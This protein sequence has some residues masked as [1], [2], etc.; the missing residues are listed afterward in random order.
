MDYYT[1]YMKYKQKYVT[2]Q[3]NY[4]EEYMK[5]QYGG[6]ISNDSVKIGLIDFI[7][8]Y[9]H[10]VA[11]GDNKHKPTNFYQFNT[12]EFKAALDNDTTSTEE[13]I[14]LVYF[15][16]RYITDDLE[17]V[18]SYVYKIYMS[19]IPFIHSEYGALKKEPAKDKE[20]SKSFKE[21][22]KD[23]FTFKTKA[24][25]EIK[26]KNPD[27][28]N[29]DIDETIAD[30]TK[31]ED[32]DK[33]NINDDEDEKNEDIEL[34]NKYDEVIKKDP[35]VE[36]I[37]TAVGQLDV[38]TTNNF[39][40][41]KT[42]GTLDKFISNLIP[43]NNTEKLD[44]YL[45]KKKNNYYCRCKILKDIIYFI[46][47]CH[48]VNP[49]S[50]G[51]EIK[52]EKSGLK[53]S[54]INIKNKILETKNE[55]LAKRRGVEFFNLFTSDR[56][57]IKIDDNKIPGYELVNDFNCMTNI[58]MTII[59]VT[60]AINDYKETALILTDQL[61]KLNMP[62]ELLNINVVK[63]IILVLKSSAQTNSHSICID[64]E[65][66]AIFEL[67]YIKESIVN[68]LEGSKI[69]TVIWKI[70]KRIKA[71]KDKYLSRDAKERIEQ[72]K[73]L[74]AFTKASRLFFSDID[75]IIFTLTFTN[76]FKEELGKHIDAFT[77]GIE[78]LFTIIA[79]YNSTNTAF[80]IVGGSSPGGKNEEDK[81][82]FDAFLLL[83]KGILTGIS[84]YLL[85]EGMKDIIESLGVDPVGLALGSIKLFL[86]AA[87]YTRLILNL[88]D[89]EGYH[90]SVVPPTIE[91]QIK[92]T[93]PYKTLVTRFKTS[94]TML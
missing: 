53:F 82:K 41:L 23:I 24:K 45:D 48:L 76:N 15:N 27:P 52:L 3:K 47:A 65:K 30:Q 71:N 51:K 88:K 10:W 72:Q 90:I 37:M 77:N 74:S 32:Q 11:Q 39:E 89:I 83:I 61:D 7:R 22:M 81:H 46:L 36:L 21:K 2:L 59:N 93:Q 19:M 73:T 94:S 64:K 28:L 34:N 12:S 91:K 75:L 68:D 6:K 5:T 50:I 29:L 87:I 84:I 70:H 92:E 43:P 35:N 44:M 38:D 69:N 31:S 1:K 55:F 67:K 63:K 58:I 13:L 17:I 40:L 79:K 56:G 54:Y 60:L 80:V 26:A 42:A 78:L 49:L 66:T 25:T 62:I 20:A 9:E 57:Y 85:I 33:G 4:S 16:S 18:L 86:S 8:Y 14:K